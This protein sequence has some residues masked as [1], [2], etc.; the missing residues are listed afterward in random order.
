M[1]WVFPFVK[2]NS[3]LNSSNM[4]S[5]MEVQDIEMLALSARPSLYLSLR[6]SARVL[7]TGRSSREACGS[8]LDG[9]NS[10]LGGRAALASAIRIER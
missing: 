6:T 10:C 8:P 2:H 4:E 9:T 3:D 1:S 5:L 7:N